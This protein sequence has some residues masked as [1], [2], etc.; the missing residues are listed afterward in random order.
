V[1]QREFWNGEVGE[2]WV[3]EHAQLERVLS[4]IGQAAIDEAKVTSGEKV[5]DVGCGCGSTTLA[6]AQA[7][8]AGGRVVGVDISA[9]MLAFAKARGGERNASFELADATTYQPDVAFDVIHS[10]FGV[11]FFEDPHAAFANLARVLRPGGRIAFVCWRPQSENAW[12][13]VPMRAVLRFAAPPEPTPP[14]APGPFAFADAARVRS[15]LEGAGFTNVRISPRESPMATGAL[16][17]AT[18]Y[19]M[20]NGPAARLA[21]TYDAATQAKMKDAVREALRP[22]ETKAGVVLPAA[23]WVVTANKRG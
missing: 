18:D 11:M 20:T 19:A 23:Q 10:R 4:S 16:E 7:V 13:T 21:T 12:V 3:T 22:F 6:L 1:D 2:K 14:D 5:L 9:P 8:G 17:E 15:I